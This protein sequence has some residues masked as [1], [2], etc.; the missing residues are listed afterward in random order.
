MSCEVWTRSY[1]WMVVDGMKGRPPRSVPLS[2]RESR[3]LPPVVPAV[4]YLAEGGK[5]N[6]AE[7]YS[8]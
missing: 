3:P 1:Q 5:Q 8:Q 6:E 4:P 7:W 2:L